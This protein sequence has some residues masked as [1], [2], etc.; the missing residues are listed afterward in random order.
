MALP[1]PI[2]PAQTDAK[3]PIDQQLMDAI[4]LNQEY[5][6][7]QLGAGS[8]GG[9]INFRVNGYLNRIKALLDLGAGKHLDGGIISNAVTFSA[10]KLYL[11]NTGTSGALEVDVLR[12]K[13]VQHGIV[14]IDPSYSGAIQSIGRLGSPQNTQAIS[15]ATPA[16]N[17]QS[18]ARAKSTINVISVSK[19][20]SETLYVFSGAGLLD[21]DYQIGK[22]IE[23]AGCTNGANNGSFTITAVNYDGLASVMTNNASG[24]TEVTAGTGELDLWEYTYLAS[25][26]PNF[27]V[28]EVVSM[29]GHTNVAND[30]NEPIHKVNE[31]GNNIWLYNAGG[32]AQAGVAGQAKANRFI[33]S[34]ASAV[35]DTSYIVGE[36]AEF[37]GHL[38]GNNN[39]QF[40]I[41][42]VNEGG[43]NLI[44]YNTTWAGAIQGGAQGTAN[45]L[46]WLYSMPTDPTG[47]ILVGEKVVITGATSGGN[48]GTFVVT[49][50]NRFAVDNIEVYNPAGVTQVGVAGTLSTNS[51][52]I[53]FAEDFSAFYVAGTSKIALEGVNVTDTDGREYDV[54]DVNKGGFS[55]YNVVIAEA[56]GVST[57][58]TA[59]GRVAREVRTIFID[60]PRLEI[61]DTISTRYLQK[62]LSATFAAGAIDADT[63]LS[64]DI[65]EV[66][67]GLPSSMVLSLS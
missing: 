2:A 66:P 44:V 59:Q 34:Y 4:R 54:I 36:L 10:A 56:S 33:Y 7:S 49:T 32:V 41:V 20:G 35:D 67:E 18:I 14:S 40:N 21:S 46:R 39:G 63:I 42:A 29:S 19:I 57:N 30:L 22:E 17:T 1:Y 48:N 58:V 55:N 37:S 38:D 65:L 23:I 52:I 8:A 3:S 11:E 60:R 15:L 27:V 6:D 53:K 26:D 51:K 62:D 61:D 47:E 25:L 16:V 28:G 5:L 12:H 31:A 13:E 50:V 9:I 24:V 45:T 43:N 64:M